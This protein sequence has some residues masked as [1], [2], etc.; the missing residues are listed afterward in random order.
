MPRIYDPDAHAEGCYNFDKFDNS[1]DNHDRKF[2]GGRKKAIKKV[3]RGTKPKTID[4]SDP[5]S[6]FSVSLSQ[7]LLKSI[8]IQ[9]IDSGAAQT[10]TPNSFPQIP[11]PCNNNTNL[12]HTLNLIRK[13][14]KQSMRKGNRILLHS[15]CVNLFPTVL[16][17]SGFENDTYIQNQVK[18]VLFYDRQQR[19]AANLTSVQY[20]REC[21]QNGLKTAAAN[22]STWELFDPTFSSRITV[23]R[24][25]NIVLP[26]RA[27][28][29]SARCQSSEEHQDFA[30]R[31]FIDLGRL[32]TVYSASS[33]PAA[34]TDI[35]LGALN[36]M[37]VGSHNPSATNINN[38]GIVGDV[39]VKW[40]EV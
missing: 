5:M 17:G 21:D 34:S 13:G 1:K 10:Y 27:A 18:L 7:H 31:E 12:I 16:V 8:D 14:D 29:G 4:E 30:I 2:L 24:K 37:V 39:R 3:T 20:L 19:S 11:I 33:T 15:A 22:A 32:E 9:F 38:F 40:E 23:I 6:R 35:E 25:W 36:L 26:A 28:L